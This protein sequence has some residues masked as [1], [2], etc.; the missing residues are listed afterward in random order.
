MKKYN[1]IMDAPH[2]ALWKKLP[3]HVS[4]PAS[5]V[6][7]KPQAR[8]AGNFGRMTNTTTRTQNSV[9]ST[10]RGGYGRGRGRGGQNRVQKRNSTKDP[11]KTLHQM[12]EFLLDQ[13]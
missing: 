13:M 3:T 10:S 12:M 4:P 11:K 6:P 5:A 9:P 7:P 2:A 1:S 8:I